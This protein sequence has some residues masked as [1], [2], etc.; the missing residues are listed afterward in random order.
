LILNFIANQNAFFPII[1]DFYINFQTQ[2]LSQKS[3]YFFWSFQ[4]IQKTEENNNKKKKSKLL[5]F[6]LK[7]H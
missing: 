6:P 5:F 2:I 7:N 3:S 1:P 4:R